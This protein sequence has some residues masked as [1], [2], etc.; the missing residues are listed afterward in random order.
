MTKKIKQHQGQ[1]IHQDI[2]TIHSLYSIAE[3]KFR[4]CVELERRTEMR[5]AGLQWISYLRHQRVPPLPLLPSNG[6]AVPKGTRKF[7][8][9]AQ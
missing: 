9:G 4:G 1:Y 6:A 5:G 7:F 3:S 8:T 2:T